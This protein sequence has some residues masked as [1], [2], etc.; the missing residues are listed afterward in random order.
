MHRAG[1]EDPLAAPVEDADKDS[2]FEEGMTGYVVSIISNQTRVATRRLHYVGKG[3]CGRTPGL[4]YKEFQWYGATKPT[5]AE[6]HKICAKCW[7]GG[8]LSESE[9]DDEAASVGT[10]AGVEGF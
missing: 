9:T 2:G 5:T 10:E 1:D 3:F 6:Y 7:P 8:L 4:H